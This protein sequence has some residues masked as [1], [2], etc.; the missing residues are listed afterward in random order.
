MS[1]RQND[2]SSLPTCVEQYLITTGAAQKQKIETVFLKQKGEFNVN[3]RWTNIHAE[4]TIDVEKHNFVWK[5]WA[6]PIQVTDQYIEGIGSLII[7]LLGILRLKKFQGKEVDQ[8][9][10]SRFLAEMI[11]Y[12]TAFMGNYI[13]WKELSNLAA[14]ASV[15]YNETEWACIQ[16]H[17]DSK[18]LIQS[19]TG[20]RYREQNGSFSLENWL[21][22][23]LE[24]KEFNDLTIPH[25]AQVAWEIDGEMSPYYRLEI[26]EIYYTP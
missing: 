26:T 13:E 2:L 18:N 16:F 14:E 1:L 15:T 25:K 4:Q 17:F 10:A 9:E 11:W 20:K 7:K 5:A 24:Y 8:G 3:G 19:I 6:G 21:I 23:E 22:S 12:P